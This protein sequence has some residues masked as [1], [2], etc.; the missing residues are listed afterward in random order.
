[1]Y[2]NSCGKKQVSRTL[3]ILK[4][5]VML[6]KRK[7]ICSSTLNI[8]IFIIVV[9]SIIINAQEQTGKY[10][11]DKADSSI[12]RKKIFN[13]FFVSPGY[14]F[15]TPYT[16]NS[17]NNLNNANTN[18]DEAWGLALAELRQSSFS[19]NSNDGNMHADLYLG[20]FLYKEK[21]PMTQIRYILG[22]AGV[23]AAGYFAYKHIQRYGFIN[24]KKSK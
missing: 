17:M 5:A 16:E 9:N 24:D 8:I 21:G 23:S 1:M 2:I 22:L 20:N 10:L 3:I 6:S 15:Y 4:G 7:L 11:N 18:P 19:T 14:Q 12:V 13:P